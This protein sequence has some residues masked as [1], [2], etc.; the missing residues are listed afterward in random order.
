MELNK[1]AESLTKNE[2]TILKSL[3]KTQ[4]FNKL[5]SQTKLK[6]VELNRGLLWLE[7]K[8]L[9][10]I[11]T[12]ESELINLDSNGKL[13]LKSGLPEK[14]F[15]DAIKSK[16]LPINKLEKLSSKEQSI[17]KE[18]KTRKQIIIPELV[19]E[20]TIELTDQGK[21]LSK[22]DIKTDLL[23]TLTPEML[24]KGNWKNKQ[25]RRYDIKAPVPKFYPGKRHFV[26]L[27]IQHAKKIWLE[28]G[29]TEM[30][31]PII[32]TSFWTFDALF[33]P[34]DHPA[35]EM[36]DTFFLDGSG[37]LPDKKLV[38][39][40]RRS[41]EEGWKYK[42]S[43]NIAKTLVLRT[44]TTVLSALTLA[45]LKESDLPAKFFAI[46]RN[47]RNEAVDWKHLFEFN[48]TEGIVVGKDLTFRDLLGYL[49]EFFS[50]MGFPQARFRPAYFPYTECSVEI[51]V[52]HPKRKTWVELG[53]AGIFRPEVV[54]PLLGKDIQV[55]AWGPGFDR[56]IKDY[57]NIEDIRDLYKNEIKQL[58]EIK[59]WFK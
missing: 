36:Q 25:F 19:K 11:N 24:M 1:V 58:R 56:I 13:Y 48:Q 33:A 38:D 28:M 45:K 43:E 52:F 27:A 57:Y 9:I 8:N 50:K 3:S 29:F 12:K 49:K 39:K 31:G 30:T 18:L 44:H 41:H 22:L 59:G 2:I 42:W 26:N 14:R 55:L 47:Y 34:Q 16:P 20:R 40:V 4:D 32:N 53:G 21:R 17:V 10:K 15:L 5:L 51:D 6:E 54:E 46:G 37:K 7:H 35:R 23:E